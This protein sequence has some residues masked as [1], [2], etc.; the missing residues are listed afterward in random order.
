MKVP[1]QVKVRK[2]LYSEVVDLRSVRYSHR[3]SVVAFNE[4]DRI[5]T[6]PTAVRS[7]VVQT[8]IFTTI[9][10][11]RVRDPGALPRGPRVKHNRLFIVAGLYLFLK[12]QGHLVWRTSLVNFA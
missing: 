6:L 12:L 4:L 7:L 1:T 3:E 2:Y 9:I 11:D 8:T 5:F 10:A